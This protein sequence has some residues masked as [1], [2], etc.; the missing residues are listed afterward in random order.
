VILRNLNPLENNS[1]FLFGPRQVGKTHLVKKY[2]EDKSY[3]HIN[4]LL[5]SEFIK[6]T[7]NLNVFRDEVLAS[8]AEYIFVD[9][10]QRVPSLLNEIHNLIELPVKQKFIMTGS[11]ARKLKRGGANLLGGRALYYSLFPLS[12]EELKKE[13]KFNL[14]SALNYGLLPKIYLIAQRNSAEAQQYLKSYVEVYLKEEIEAEALSRNISGFINF[15]KIA[16]HNNSD[17]INY[18]NVA[19]DA[20]LTSVTAKEYYKILEDTLVGFFLPTYSTSQRKRYKIAP[21]F[22][23]FDTGVIRALQGK[24]SY[25]I[26]AKTFEY[27]MLFETF[28]INEVRKINSYYNKEWQLSFLRT[29]ND[30]ELDLIIETPRNEICAI[31]IKSKEL[32][33]ARDFASSFAAITNSTNKKIFRKICVCRG[34][35]RRVLNDVEIINYRD[36]L[37]WL[38]TI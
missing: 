29:Q 8:N 35:K 18:S 13:G 16:A 31:E 21:K 23:F 2:L 32:P 33:E 10:I 3:L 24:I 27:G 37:K 30:V 36:F 20:N 4:L 34:E 25:E 26:E 38:V 12:Y 7:A 28:I 15:L 19:R 14:D 9:E 5:T 11:S 1:F 6:Y 22:Y 17:P